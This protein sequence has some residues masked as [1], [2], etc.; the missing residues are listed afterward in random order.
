MKTEVDEE[1]F[2]AMMKVK[3]E[4]R[5]YDNMLKRDPMPIPYSYHSNKIPDIEGAKIIQARSS[6]SNTKYVTLAATVSMSEKMLT[7]FLIFKGQPP[8]CITMPEFTT[9]PHAGM[10]ACQEKA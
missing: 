1:D 5:N 4:G 9:Y 10:Y 8:G 7:P 6:T 3:L 2:I